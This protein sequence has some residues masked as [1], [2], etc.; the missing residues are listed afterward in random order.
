MGAI[1]LSIKILYF[2]H[3]QQNCGVYQYGRAACGKTSKYEG[4]KIV[5]REIDSQGAFL[6]AVAGQ[7]DAM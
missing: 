7:Q 1:S 2:N 5:Y 3:I 6:E 4:F